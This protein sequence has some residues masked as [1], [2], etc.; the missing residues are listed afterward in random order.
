M[1]KPNNTNLTLHLRTGGRLLAPSVHQNL[2]E[3]IQKSRVL[4]PSS[5][6]FFLDAHWLNCMDKNNQHIS[7]HKINFYF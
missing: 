5:M 1:H 6:V 4:P 7:N 3:M 2:D